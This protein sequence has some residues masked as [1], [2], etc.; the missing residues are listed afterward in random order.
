LTFK[1]EHTV[2]IK[3]IA[4][5]EYVVRT[6][7]CGCVSATLEQKLVLLPMRVSAGDARSWRCVCP[8]PLLLQR[9]NDPV[10]TGV[11]KTLLPGLCESF[12]ITKL[13]HSDVGAGHTTSYT[14]TAFMLSTS[15]SRHG[16]Q[17]IARR[18]RKDLFS[19]SANSGFVWMRLIMLLRLA[20]RVDEP[21]Y[22]NITLDKI[23]LNHY[24]LKS[25]SVRSLDPVV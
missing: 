6:A 25:K 9:F 21:R 18:T 20:Q 14:R 1:N 19:V 22:W 12:V 10:I 3:T 23:Q 8:K 4:N 17:W 16:N 15:T 2:H 13:S 7:G 24:V 11:I 5:T